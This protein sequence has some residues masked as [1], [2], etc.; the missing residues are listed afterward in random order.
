MSHRWA[1]VLAALSGAQRVLLVGHVNPDADALGSALATGMALR[2]L[3]RD[4]IERI[5]DE[6]GEA[7]IHDELS[8]HEY[9]FDADELRDLIEHPP[10]L[11]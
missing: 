10:T 7:R 6:Q 11:Q 3:G 5:I 4:E 2:S 1:P 8:N 9:V